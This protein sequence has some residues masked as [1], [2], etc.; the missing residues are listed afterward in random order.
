MTMIAGNYTVTYDGATLGQIKDGFEMEEPG[1]GTVE[2]ITGD[3]YGPNAVQDGVTQG[4]NCFINFVLM[5]YDA[6][7]VRLLLS[8]GGVAAGAI[9][10]PGLLISGLAKVLV[11]TKVSGPNALPATTRTFQYSIIDD[12]S[13][14]RYAMANRHRIIPIRMRILPFLNAGVRT[15]FIDV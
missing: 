4:G 7:K 11:L 13:P 2:K 1:I 8:P 12:D 15:Y 10:Q 5:E 14:I 6:S 3:T 9:V